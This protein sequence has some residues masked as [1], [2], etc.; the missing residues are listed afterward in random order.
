MTKRA[1]LFVTLWALFASSADAESLPDHCAILPT[2][3]GPALIRQ[4]S[5]GSPADVSGF[6]TPSPS[7]VLAVEQRLPAL[8]RKSGHK[9]K[10]SDSYRQ[11]VG[12]TSRGKKLIYV[13]SFPGFALDHSKERDWH[14]TGVTVCDGG[15][16]FW[17]V[18]FDPADYT[19]HDLQF[20]GE[21]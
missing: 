2:S 12:V 8:L 10:L 6:W 15:D 20:N 14:V 1:Q 17:G 5:R 9:L 7:Q 13:N 3:Q 21:A 19:F 16:V 18:E 4:C 11:Y